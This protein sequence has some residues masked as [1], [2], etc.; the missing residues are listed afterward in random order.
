M[1]GAVR[2][3]TDGTVTGTGTITLD[4]YL[5]GGIDLNADGTNAGTVQIRDNNSSG[6]VII[7]ASSVNGKTII[8]PFHAPSGKIYYSVS[9]TGA[10]AMLYEWIE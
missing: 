1:A 4:S 5:F 8:A 7:D 2:P 10:D 9:G 3:I 6:T